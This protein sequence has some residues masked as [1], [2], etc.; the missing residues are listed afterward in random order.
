[1]ARNQK[2]TRL[3][4]GRG[5][6]GVQQQDRSMVITFDDGSI[7]TVQTDGTARAPSASSGRVAA[8]RQLGTILSLDLE[9]G[10]TLELH[11]LE[12]TASVMV[13]AKDHT[14]EYAD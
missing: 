11:T 9:G 8:V 13:R 2:L 14:L 12:A 3:I 10:A 7:M 5:I 6:A 4:K 1:M